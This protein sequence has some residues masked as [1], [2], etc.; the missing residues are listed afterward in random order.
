MSFQNI[1]LFIGKI[2]C[3]CDIGVYPHNH[4]SIEQKIKNEI[5]VSGTIWI[6][7][8]RQGRDCG[9]DSDRAARKRMPL[10]FSVSTERRQLS[11]PRFFRYMTIR[12]F[13]DRIYR[14]P[15]AVYINFVRGY[16]NSGMSGNSGNRACRRSCSCTL[17]A[18]FASMGNN[19]RR[20]S[21]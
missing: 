4:Q 19:G 2:K 21:R 8:W 10:L 12:L 18:P 1:D 20:Y 13:S 11:L 7:F 5:D 14:T 16:G 3:T 6:L 15:C 17:R 9:Y